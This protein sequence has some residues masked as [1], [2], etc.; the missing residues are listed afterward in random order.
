MEINKNNPLLNMGNQVVRS[1]RN[2]VKLPVANCALYHIRDRSDEEYLPENLGDLIESMEPNGCVDTPITAVKTKGFSGYEDLPDDLKNSNILII[3]GG[4]RYCTAK[5]LHW[6]Y[7]DG[8]LHDSLD[9]VE[10]H[11]LI[12]EENSKRKDTVFGRRIIYISKSFEAL[13]K[14]DP[15]LTFGSL[16]RVMKIDR[17]TANTAK[18]FYENFHKSLV[19]QLFSEQDISKLTKGQVLKIIELAKSDSI[20]KEHLNDKNIIALQ[21]QKTIPKRLEFLSGLLVESPNKD[22]LIKKINKSQKTVTV[23][24]TFDQMEMNNKEL[25]KV[26]TNIKAEFKSF[27]NK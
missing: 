9:V 13:S 2:L 27:Q 5:H 11:R 7:I 23:E 1:E 15:D 26:L 19:A 21:I 10:V 18:G 3:V 22:G 4:R 16:G 25:T 14:K 20:I 12:E 24:L 8:I 6:Q 17:N